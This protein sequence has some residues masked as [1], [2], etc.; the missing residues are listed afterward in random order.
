MFEGGVC[1]GSVGLEDMVGGSQ[2][3]G[4]GE[5]V[6]GGRIVPGGEG[7]VAFGFGFV[8]HRV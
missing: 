4:I 6:D 3:D 7:C 2:G 5:V 8:G 1:G